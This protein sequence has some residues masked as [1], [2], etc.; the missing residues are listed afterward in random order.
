MNA[1]FSPWGNADGLISA[2]LGDRMEGFDG[3]RKASFKA[4]RHKKKHLGFAA[5]RNIH[6]QLRHGLFARA[7]IPNISMDSIADSLHNGK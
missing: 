3:L 7:R 6:K 1:G 2:S 4:M 5:N